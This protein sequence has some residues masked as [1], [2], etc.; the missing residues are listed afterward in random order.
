MDPY[1][2]IRTL[3]RGW[4]PAV[5]AASVLGSAGAAL[6]VITPPTYKSTTELYVAV[7]TSSTASDLAQGAS[8]AEQRIQ[9]FVAVAT[10]AKVLAPVIDELGLETD[11][12]S[13]AEHVSASSPV[14]S[15]LIDISATAVSPEAAAALASAVGESLTDVVSTKLERSTG[16]DTSAFHLETVAPA[17]EPETPV[18][19]S[20]PL[21]I[22][23]GVLLGTAFGL[24]FGAV[25]ASLGT[26][27]ETRA[28]TEGIVDAPVIG[29]IP[30]DRTVTGAPLL[31]HD[32]TTT[33]RHEAFRRLRTNLQFVIVA[34]ADAKS[35]TITSSVAS[36]GKSTTACNLALALAQSGL[37]V[38]LVDGDLRRPAVASIMG[39]EGEYGLTD[40]LIGRGELDTALQ[41]WGRDGLHILP[42]GP[43]PPNP[44][45]LLE[46]PAMRVLIAELEAAFDLV[47]VDAPPLLPVSDAVILSNVTSGALMVSAM[48]KTTRRQLAD[49]RLILSDAGASVRGAIMTMVRSRRGATN[50]YTLDRA[51]GDKAETRRTKIHDS[52]ASMNMIERTRR[53]R[54]AA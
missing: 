19:P 41:P 50:P 34:G 32:S 9:S 14:D 13:L 2:I 5:V 27:L 47:I 28:E 43:I 22:A 15:V 36:E 16:A 26:R 42:S 7:P 40:L 45:E 23:L 8:A 12:I 33:V 11:P 49:A 35:V 10:T 44:T 21:N 4:I 38:V 29:E 6:A 1:T 52:A 24:A 53:G 54:R 3:R 18:S 37:R 20:V 39:I 25:R 51:R 48:H 17:I 30:D 46:S 31:V